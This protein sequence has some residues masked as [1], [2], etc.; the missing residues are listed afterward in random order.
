MVV[1]AVCDGRHV[2]VMDGSLRP[3]TRPKRKNVRHLALGGAVHPVISAGQSVADPLVRAWLA[4]ETG[5]HARRHPEAGSK[6]GQA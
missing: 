3:G 6:E 2:L 1:V 4:V 5:A